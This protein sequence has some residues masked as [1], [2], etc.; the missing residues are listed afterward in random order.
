MG[1]GLVAASRSPA[2]AAPGDDVHPVVQAA[3][4][5]PLK[6]AAAKDHGV[7]VENLHF[8]PRRQ[9]QAVVTGAV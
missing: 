2:G 9:L 7:A 5:Q 4:A 3:C 6:N 1:A 8:G